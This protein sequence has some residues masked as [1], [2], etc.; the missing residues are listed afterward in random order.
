MVRRRGSFFLGVY[1]RGVR[2]SS[3]TG[4]LASLALSVLFALGPASARA[5]WEV[6]RTS[7]RA[8]AEQAARA[9]RERPTDE[10]LARRLVALAG[11]GGASELKARFQA[12]ADAAGATFAD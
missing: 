2:P 5:D 3:L 8:T 10:A 11:K 9:L 6:R 4:A 1:P 12:R 7:S